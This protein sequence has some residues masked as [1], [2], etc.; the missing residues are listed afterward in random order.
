[1]R[2]MDQRHT[3][4]IV[5]TIEPPKHGKYFWTRIT[6]ALIGLLVLVVIIAAVTS[7]THAHIT[8]AMHAAQQLMQH[9]NGGVAHAYYRELCHTDPH[10]H[11]CTGVTR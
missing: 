5:K 11:L 1:M 7:G 10:N 3:T 4:P 9:P 6:A 2:T 8:P